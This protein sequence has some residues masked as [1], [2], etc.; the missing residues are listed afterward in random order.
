MNRGLFN[1]A[2]AFVVTL[3]LFVTAGSSLDGREL[4][5]QGD[6]SKVVQSS[7]L[8]GVALTTDNSTKLIFATAK[9]ESIRQ[10]VYTIGGT[11]E[12]TGFMSTTGSGTLTN[13]QIPETLTNSVMFIAY[14]NDSNKLE[15]SLY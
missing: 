7:G 2:M 3:A 6:L 9:D 8:T 12:T 1:Q 4:I 11:S 5:I 10:D 14:V 15:Y 13:I